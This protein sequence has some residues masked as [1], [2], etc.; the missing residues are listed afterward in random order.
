MKNTEFNTEYFLSNRYF[1]KWVKTPDDESDRFWENWLQNHKLHEEAFHKAKSILE[2]IRYAES[3]SS[4][5]RKAVILE[6]ILAGKTSKIHKG[7]TLGLGNHSI[8]PLIYKSIAAVL[9]IGISF[10]YF[11]DCLPGIGITKETPEVEYLSRT[12]P[13]GQKSTFYLPDNS[14]VILNSGSTIR[15]PKNFSED[16][17]EVFLSGEAYFDVAADSVSPF[18]VR[19]G[20]LYVH[21]HGTSFNVKAYDG[22]SHVSVAL[23]RGLVSVHPSQLEKPTKPYFLKPGEKLVVSRDF[24]EAHRTGFDYD[25]EFGWKL[26]KLVFSESG[27]GEFVEKLERWYGVNVEIEGKIP[28]Q[29]SL[30]GVFENESLENVLKG[31]SYSR[32]ISYKIQDDKVTLR[33]P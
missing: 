7:K 25:Q 9:L 4:Q 8:M 23:E 16:F 29:W 11:L 15:F 17:R 20:E 24:E 13:F 6:N 2:N 21:V 22:Y 18:L 27:I 19:S 10:C 33:L 12:N 1:V 26:G 32:N 28:S 5:D 14:K 3:E 30:N 31:L